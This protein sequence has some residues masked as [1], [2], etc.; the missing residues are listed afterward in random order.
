MKKVVIVLLLLT[1]AV[2]AVMVYYIFVKPAPKAADLLPESTF[3]FLD[4]PDFSQSRAEFAKTELY[5]LWHEPEVQAFL[6][7]PL[8]AAREALINLG[9]PKEGTSVAEQ[10][11][12]AMQGEVFLAL[13]RITILPSFSPGVVLGVDARRKRIEAAAA[14]YSLKNKLK[15]SNPTG[16]FEESKFLGVKYDIWEAR[17]GLLI[18]QAS[19]NSL[20]V[21]TLG[22]DTM[23]DVIACY[24]G[25]TSR[26]YKRLSESPKYR[27][28]LQ[29]SSKNKEFLAYCNFEEI[30]KLAGPLL[31]LSPQTS[32]FYGK[33]SRLQTSAASMTFVNGGIEDVGFVAY[34]SA[35]P[36]PVPATQRKTLALTTPDTLVYWT[37]STD[38]AAMYDEAMQSLSQSGNANLM[39]AVGLFQQSL[40]N[41][42]VRIREDVLQKLGP[43]CAVLGD[44]QPG[45]RV[46]DA[47]IV[48]E[49]AKGAQLQTAIDGAMNA[50]KSATWGDN[51][52]WDE[53]EFAG[54]KLR[55]MHVGTS[56]LAP[57]YTTTDQF[58]ILASTPDYARQLLGQLK[59]AKPTLAQSELYTRSMKRLPAGGSSYLYADLRGVFEPLYAF[60]K[61]T[62]TQQGD[63]GVVDL[64]KLPSSPTIAK[65]LFPFVST[66]I[67]EP[68]Q[69]TSTSFSP[70]G[71]ALTLAAGIGGAIWVSDILGPTM[72]QF[73]PP[74]SQDGFGAEL[75][76]KRLQIRTFLRRQPKIKR[77]RLKLQR[78]NSSSTTVRRILDTLLKLLRIQRSL[79]RRSQ[80]ATA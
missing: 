3:V 46:P 35:A 15:A 28:V 5:G 65:H 19:L 39:A 12:D 38:L 13:T 53:T 57:T 36:Q 6:E 71:K 48:I 79:I 72:K 14:L 16:K 32:G 54:Q 21:F 76:P 26:D 50:L 47:A 33:L 10:I 9:A 17:P 63:N 64:K 45:T 31:A 4:I 44:W 24:A 42:G 25:Q 30:L 58:F 78:R 18:C 77:Q 60:G 75:R 7:K 62:W 27:N 8:A 49:I 70:F 68:L 34:S 55:T 69:E 40:G 80:Q 23:R 43:E 2:A 67:S 37:S 74:G 11:L 73:T 56:V 29:H 51:S 66:T 1:A 41:Q 52:P 61:D 22:E 59:G 20:Y